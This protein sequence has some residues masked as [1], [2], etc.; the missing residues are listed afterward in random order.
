M[1]ARS[2]MDVPAP[3]T[4]GLLKAGR[5]WAVPL[6]GPWED[7]TGM[8]AADGVMLL[9]SNT[10]SWWILQTASGMPPAARAVQAL[11]L[12]TQGQKDGEKRLTSHDPYSAYPSRSCHNPPALAVHHLELGAPSVHRYSLPGDHNQAFVMQMKER[13]YW[14]EHGL[15]TASCIYQKLQKMGKEENRG[16]VLLKKRDK[17]ATEKKLG[18]QRK[19]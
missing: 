19:S 2:G 4:T 10:V 9:D 6:V 1:K 17:T 12:F 14:Y 11:R 5:S 16:N 15:R 7:S 13:S 18:R 8:I 3:R